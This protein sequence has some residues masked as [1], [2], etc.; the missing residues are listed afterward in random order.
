[1]AAKAQAKK[2]FTAAVDK[3]EVQAR[4]AATIAANHEAEHDQKQVQQPPRVF[5]QQVHPEHAACPDSPSKAD[6]LSSKARDFHEAISKVALA[7]TVGTDSFQTSVSTAVPSNFAASFDTFATSFDKSFDTFRDQT[8]ILSP[9]RFGSNPTF[10]SA[11]NENPSSETEDEDIFKDGEAPDYG[12][13][14]FWRE[15]YTGSSKWKKCIPPEWLF[16][17]EQFKNQRW[18][19]YLRGGSILDVGCGPSTFMSDAYDDGFHDITCADVEHNVVEMMRQKNALVRPGI[20]YMQSDACNMLGIDDRSYD[21]I[22]DKGTMDALICAGKRTVSR[23]SAEIHRVL[24][25]AGLYLCI[26]LNAPEQ[27]QSA[28]ANTGSHRL[29]RI[30]VL[31]WKP[32]PRDENQHLWMYVCR[33]VDMVKGA[34]KESSRRP[35]AGG[36][37]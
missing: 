4:K 22:V 3:A 32:R 13:P 26:S 14:D 27:M 31:T 36:A 9:R 25:D 11:A 15:V 30:E 19:R 35:A 33:K 34:G 1:V 8:T 2:D 18:H 20:K 37:K 29:W 16:S 5:L 6:A 7:K 23:C 28:I 17:Y 10:D 12:S 21:I 24:K